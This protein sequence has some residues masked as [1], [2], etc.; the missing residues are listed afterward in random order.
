M[1]FSVFQGTS[2]KPIGEIDLTTLGMITQTGVY[3]PLNLEFKDTIHNLRQSLAN[4]R[5]NGHE[6]AT[7]ATRAI[8]D[9]LPAI[10]PAGIFSHRDN[11]SCTEY[12]GLAVFDI[13]GKSQDPK[14]TSSDAVNFI[15]SIQFR[16][17]K[18]ILLAFI[19]P[20]GNGVKII[21]R[22]DAPKEKH[23]D[24]YRALKQHFESLHGFII[25]NAPDISRLM[26]LS[27]TPH[28]FR[29][30]KAEPFQFQDIPPA[31]TLHPI[32]DAK[33]NHQSLSAKISAN[34][35]A[36]TSDSDSVK[37]DAICEWISHTGIDI[38]D[39]YNEWQN[40]AFALA[41]EFGE[42]GRNAFHIISQNHAEYDATKCDA[43]YTDAIKTHRG[44]VEFGTVIHLAQLQGF[45]L[46]A[47]W[48][49]MD[50]VWNGTSAPI[51]NPESPENENNER[52]WNIIVNEKKQTFQAK[53]DTTKL[54]RFLA[55]HGIKLFKMQ[56]SEHPILVR[57]QDNICTAINDSHLKIIVKN[58][59]ESLTV[60]PHIKDAIQNA[61]SSGNS[62]RFNERMWPIHIETISN[63][64]FLRDTFS[65]GFICYKKGIVLI[66]NDSI[67]MIPYKDATGYVWENW[68]IQRDSKEMAR[69]DY[70]KHDYY[71]FLEMICTPKDS[72]ILD[73]DRFNALRWSIGYLCHNPQTT[74]NRYI[75]HFCEDNTDDMSHGGTGKSIVSKIALRHIKKVDS[76]GNRSKQLFKSNFP[77]QNISPDTQIVH[78]GDV[79]KKYLMNG[80]AEDI[81][82]S[83]T[84]GMHIEKK[85]QKP[86]YIDASNLPRMVSTG[87]AV[88][89]TPDAS[90]RRRFFLMEIYSRFS[91]E[92]QPAHEFGRRFFEH[93][94][95]E[96]DWCCFDNI[97]WECIQYAIANPQKPEY[98]S[99]TL[100][101]NQFKTNTHPEWESFILGYLVDYARP[102][103]ED[104]RHVG[105]YQPMP[106]AVCFTAIGSQDVYDAFKNHCAN[107]RANH[108][109]V[110]MSDVKRYMQMT[111][112]LLSLKL[113]QFQWHYQFKK[114]SSMMGTHMHLIWRIG[115]GE[116]IE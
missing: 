99:L 21:A 88:P 24:V 32:T 7:K 22:H 34:K 33:S 115:Q 74:D 94:W 63:P 55:S 102:D 59:I 13:D 20:S 30:F 103:A 18:H 48:Q 96:H 104:L 57:I 73:T 62:E 25:D 114:V 110:K 87:N 31:L 111:S 81:F 6:D 37:L 65:T 85:N 69:E 40:I 66:Q 108:D 90:S 54:Y 105:K 36:S 61:V 83:V 19:S 27:Q 5:A 113:P 42:N 28:T 106:D 116:D 29:N 80:F 78:F 15:N 75:V 53:I 84:D 14:W 8:K 70:Y 79:D 4:D 49:I 26:Y 3:K 86:I 89:Q 45:E 82:E 95:N 17:N 68:I 10:T 23:R 97:I 56:G 46:P 16:N 67:K 51:T 98:T 60:P 12:S 47:K 71:K 64:K 58:Y 2:P 72:D 100:L 43:K 44:L 39:H 9:S 77:Y 50:A 38:T 35:Q 109:N 93:E 92:Y 41:N 91:D 112:G 11:D 76:I 101:Q 52:F 1:K 107:I